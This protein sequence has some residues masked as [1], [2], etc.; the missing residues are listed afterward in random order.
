MLFHQ[1]DDG[2]TGL[3]LSVISDAQTQ[4]AGADQNSHGVFPPKNDNEK[5]PLPEQRCFFLQK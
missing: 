3:A 1:T 5:A 2:R 4:E